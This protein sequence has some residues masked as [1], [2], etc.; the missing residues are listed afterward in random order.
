[1]KKFNIDFVA[2]FKASCT[3]EAENRQ[4]AVK[5]FENYV[6]TRGAKLQQD[7]C[8]NEAKKIIDYEI[9]CNGDK[10]ITKIYQ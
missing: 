8:A 5:I 10:R 6:Y 3:I 9:E 7:V 1:M 2:E 4:Q